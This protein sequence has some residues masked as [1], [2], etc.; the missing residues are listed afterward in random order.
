MGYRILNVSTEMR[1]KYVERDGLEGP[2]FY[3][4]ERVLYYST[5]EGKYLDPKSDIFLSYD[6]Y[7]SYIGMQ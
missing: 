6:D 4:N 5:K 7:Q 2:F 3:G 1:E